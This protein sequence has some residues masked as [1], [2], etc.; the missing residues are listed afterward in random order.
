[1]TARAETGRPGVAAKATSSHGVRLRARPLGPL[2]HTLEGTVNYLIM[3][4][5]E[6]HACVVPR[7]AASRRRLRGRLADCRQLFSLTSTSSF[8][9]T[10]GQ[11]E[12]KTGCSRLVP[13]S[14]W[15]PSSWPCPPT[16]IKTPNQPAF[17]A[18]SSHF[19]RPVLVFPEK[20]QVGNFLKP[21]V[22]V[23]SQFHIRI[24]FGVGVYPAPAG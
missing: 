5:C 14:K 15:E 20:P 7:T 23:W 22:C 1:M 19:R 16:T 8:G 2:M 17:R 3:H 18:R 24:T 6:H 21:C 4:K 11:A 10:C 13:A 12:K 9:P